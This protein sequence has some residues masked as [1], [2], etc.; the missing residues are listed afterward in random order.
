MSVDKSGRDRIGVNTLAIWAGQV[1]VI[2]TGFVIPRLIDDSLSQ[3]ALGIWDFGWTTASYFRLLGLGMASGL[4][5]YVALY[6]AQ[7]RQVDLARAV[8]STSFMQLIVSLLTLGVAV[9]FGVIAASLFASSGVDLSTAAQWL[10]TLLG[11]GIAV[12]MYG[13]T[14][15]GILTGNH[16]WSQTVMITAAGDIVL[17][18]LMV[19][20]LQSGG[21][22]IDLGLCYAGTAL[23]TEGVR[24]FQAR[25]IHGQPLLQRSLVDL[26]MLKK[27]FRFG[28][29]NNVVALPHL[30]V[31]T[32]VNFALASAAG[33]AALA[34]YARPLS[35]TRH[36]QTLVDKFTNIFTSTTASLQGLKKDKELKA[37]YL[38][39]TRA[40]F[41][42]TLPLLLF[43]ATF[44][45]VM[46]E[47]WM[48]PDYVDVWLAPLICAGMIL[49]YT[50]A[51]STK[52]LIGL[53]Y[54]GR[55]AIYAFGAASLFL[56]VGILIGIEIG[57]SP[58]VGAIVAGV[59]LSASTGILMPFFACRRLDVTFGEYM[60][61]VIAKP[62][63]LNVPFAVVLIGSRFLLP[64]ISVVESGAVSM[65]A[66]L[67]LIA[68]YV[69][70]LFEPELRRKLFSN[71][72]F[73]RRTK[74]DAGL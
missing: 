43:V 30:I 9:G 50:A 41:S 20:V 21:G 36:A 17:F 35:L 7:E 28:V 6:N 34:I 54:H 29:K 10:V 56:T 71:M 26:R 47:L 40:A 38:L 53:N 8:S 68:L 69:S 31:I 37:F 66:G 12:R 11:V 46:V 25:R 33:P 39:S 60:R 45:D 3:A 52:T 74:K 70:F 73:R 58:R 59:S 67:V 19:W 1:I 62:I 64:D 16:L 42:M 23:V 72:G 24:L 2:V 51:P 5:R 13:W 55:V 22:L 63:I 18:V 65:A 48:G 44:G 4:N 61:S 57:W 32:G 15:R 14:A 49:P 27:L